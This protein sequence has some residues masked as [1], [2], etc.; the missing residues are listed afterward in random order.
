M[1]LELYFL[2]KE[3]Y[4][5]VDCSPTKEIAQYLAKGVHSSEETIL[6]KKSAVSVVINLFSA[7]AK[8]LWQNLKLLQLRTLPTDSGVKFYT[9]STKY[10]H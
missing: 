5:Y 10:M 2:V 4:V 6:E 1:I 9:E 7:G 3:W 8:T